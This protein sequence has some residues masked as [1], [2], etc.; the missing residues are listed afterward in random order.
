MMRAKI[1]ED[2]EQHTKFL[3][4]GRCDGSPLAGG[5]E[6]FDLVAF[7]VEKGWMHLNLSPECDPLGKVAAFGHPVGFYLP[8]A[9]SILL[10]SIMSS[11]MA[12]FSAKEV[13][14]IRDVGIEVTVA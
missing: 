7:R 14:A 5:G 12:T 13:K 3:N 2:E 11:Q 4:R 10:N 6:P 8:Y 9:S 1:E